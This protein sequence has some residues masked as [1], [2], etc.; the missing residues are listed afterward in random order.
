[1]NPLRSL[2]SAN[3]KGMSGKRSN[4]GIARPVAGAASGADKAQP[5][6]RPSSAVG[7]GQALHL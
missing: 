1:M 6:S 5:A 2:A 7:H 4:V 3:V